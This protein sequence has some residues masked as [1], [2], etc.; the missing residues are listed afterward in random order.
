[1]GKLAGGFLVLFAVGTVIVETEP[2]DRLVQADTVGV[3]PSER[4]LHVVGSLRDGEDVD[5]FAF[6][7]ARPTVIDVRLVTGADTLPVGTGHAVS[8][9]AGAGGA[10][11]GGFLPVILVY[12]SAGRLVFSKVS[13]TPNVLLPGIQVPLHGEWITLRILAW[14]GEPGPYSLQVLSLVGAVP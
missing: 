3:L 1:M 14:S 12:D 11:S 4:P 10:E 8:G 9:T 5:S 6:F 13:S 7:V 2:N